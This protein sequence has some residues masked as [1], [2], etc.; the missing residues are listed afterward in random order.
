MTDGL[1]LN[2]FKTATLERAIAEGRFE[3]LTAPS[4]DVAI[5]H[6]HRYEKTTRSAK[7][8]AFAIYQNGANWLEREAKLKPGDYRIS[9]TKL[10]IKKGAHPSP[11]R[12]LRMFA[13]IMLED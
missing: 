13:A 12:V 5:F 10:E 8:N 9:T 7:M 11:V 4:S 2:A 6:P 1:E 3:I